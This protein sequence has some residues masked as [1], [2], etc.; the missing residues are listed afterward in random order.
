MKLVSR[1]YEV[2]IVGGGVI[3]LSIARKLDK[4]GVRGVAIVERA[5][6]GR[7][8][9]WAAAG[10][11]SPNI[12]TDVGSVFH[13]LCRESL[14]LYPKFAA[15]LLEETGIDIE[16]DRAGTLVAAFD[17]EE[18]GRLLEEH[19]DLGKVGIDTE[20]LSQQEVLMAEPKLS[21]LVRS[22]LGFPNDWQVENRKLLLALKRYS[23][24]NGI[25]KFENT[26]IDELIVQDGRVVGARGSNDEF[27][28]GKTILATGAWT[29]LIKFGGQLAP[30]SIRPIRGQMIWFECAERLLNK[31]VYGPGCYLVPRRDGRILAGSTSEDVGFEKG[32]TQEA[33]GQ[34]AAAAQELVPAL[35][36][37]EVAG[38]WSGL[39]P[40]SDDP[41]PVVGAIEGYRDLIIATGHYR[42]G[43]LLAPLTAQMAANEKYPEA[44]S[45]NRFALA[46]NSASV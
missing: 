37:L 41:M 12:E 7:E 24:L 16:L 25:E 40:R 2:L 17:D 5:E 38:S 36:D 19:A 20:V 43:I 22:G 6:L 28:A 23:E 13:R 45:P 10:M 31:V 33:I 8:A 27:A 39:R 35:R 15:E 3:G 42:N 34:L 14:E 30:F 18:S 32:V 11:L 1:K 9:S 44:F 46:R 4:C 21:S 26:Q 29:S